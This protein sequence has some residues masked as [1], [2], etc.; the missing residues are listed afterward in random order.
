MEGNTNDAKADTS[1]DTSCAVVLECL[2]E[3]YLVT[4]ADGE[5]GSRRYTL[6]VFDSPGLE[7]F[8]C[9]P[10]GAVTLSSTSSKSIPSTNLVSV[11]AENSSLSS[12]NDSDPLPKSKVSS[13]KPGKGVETSTRTPQEQSPKPSS[14]LLQSNST[15]PLRTLRSNL[16]ETNFLFETDAVIVKRNIRPPEE[17]GGEEAMT[18]DTEDKVKINVLRWRWFMDLY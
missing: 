15:T 18:L 13:S 11:P 4:F 5:N 1:S 2:K 6:S 12:P 16:V 10:D 14:P 7:I 9:T 8:P 17:N 3:T